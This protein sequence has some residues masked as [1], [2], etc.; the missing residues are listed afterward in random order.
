MLFLRQ[1]SPYQLPTLQGVRIVAQSMWTVEVCWWG[2]LPCVGCCMILPAPLPL[3]LSPVCLNSRSE[4]E[5][6][7]ERVVAW[8]PKSDLCFRLALSAP[9]PWMEQTEME[10]SRKQGWEASQGAW[11]P[12]GSSC[13]LQAAPVVES[14]QCAW[15]WVSALEGREHSPLYPEEVES[16]ALEWFGKGWATSTSRLGC[17]S[18]CSGLPSPCPWAPRVC[19]LLGTSP[20]FLPVLIQVTSVRCHAWKPTVA[21][22]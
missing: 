19:H 18:R 12:A 20:G 6:N 1:A 11:R 9:V 17:K 14:L 3:L 13:L 7:P 16:R 15:H 10:V 4:C 8:L 21:S 22:L 2:L 5:T